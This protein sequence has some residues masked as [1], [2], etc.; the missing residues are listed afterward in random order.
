M[1]TNESPKMKPVLLAVDNDPDALGN[2]KQELSNRYSVDYDVI[3]EASADA[4]M[5]KLE[6]LS[7]HNRRV[8]VVLADQNL[9]T[10]EINDGIEFLR[11]T[12]DMYQHAKCALLVE[13][14]ALEIR[15]KVFRTMVLGQIDYYIVK[16]RQFP[17]EQFHRIIV[18]FMHDWTKSER[19]V[20]P[21][22]KIVGEKSSAEVQQLNTIL[23]KS[24]LFPEIY[25]KDT[26]Q[27]R[28]L[29]EKLERTEDELP[30][31]F[32]PGREPLFSPSDL[33]IYDAL[34]ANIQPEQQDFDV[35][36]IGAGPA[37]LAAA[38]YGASEG[39][40][41][42]VLESRI[43]GG[44]ARSSSMIRNYLGFPRGISGRDLTAQA[45]EQ[46][47]MFGATFHRRAAKRLRRSGTKV[48]VT[49]S[50]KTE[51][52]G[53]TVIIATGAE[54]KLLEDLKGGQLETLIGKGV[55]YGGA[56]TEAQTMEGR[57]V[58]VAG[59]GN[60]AAQAATHLSK[61]ASRVTLLVRKEALGIR[62]S[63]YLVEQIKEA[64][65][66]HYRLNTRV[67]SARG[68]EQLEYL[69][70]EDS[71]SGDAAEE[72]ISAAALFVLIGANPNTGW[73]PK[74]IVRDK[75]GFIITGRDLGRT[76]ELPLDWYLDRAPMMR[77]TSMPGVFA[78]GDV[79]HG[80]AHRVAS[81]AGEGAT[82]I[83]LVQEYLSNEHTDWKHVRAL[84][85]RVSK[86]TDGMFEDL[87]RDLSQLG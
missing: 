27:G 75:K 72:E 3:C 17:D 87:S 76:V 18:E 58:Y 84:L 13:W 62:M 74:H 83:R 24:G 28:E 85:A 77:E 73:L 11:R 51:V 48:V 19:R 1:S 14:E 57:E 61:Y 12:R 20:A 79:R 25:S 86:L 69:V 22:A 33:E 54:Y 5:R 35:I 63:E 67:V 32:L 81:V 78:A 4:G 31:V 82:V 65:N 46:A 66:I 40:R 47:R 2:V 29:L 42:L 45:Y 68:A 26:P 16:P 60:S 23:D 53:R 6:D 70:I 39:L 52:V 44:Q 50:D 59:G 41:T 56:V 80:S 37:G 10:N 71:T 8:A 15:H 43:T 34:E 9:R 55:Y 7:K 38:V 21:L 36:I 30:A 64:K 49:L